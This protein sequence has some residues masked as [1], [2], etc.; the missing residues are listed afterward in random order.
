M[1]I[2]NG[3]GEIYRAVGRRDVETRRVAFATYSIELSDGVP[4]GG[5]VRLV[6]GDDLPLDEDLVLELGAC[7]DS[8]PFRARWPQAADRFYR[9]EPTSGFVQP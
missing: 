2:R 9:I 4:T 5:C 7:L 8:L 3:T 1:F 6:D